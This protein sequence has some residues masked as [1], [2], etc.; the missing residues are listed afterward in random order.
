MSRTDAEVALD[1][2]RAGAAVVAARYG[3]PLD[4]HGKGGL[5]F[6]TD[7]DLEA[8][9][10]AAILAVLRTERQEDAIVGEESGA[11]GAP[12]DRTWLVDPLC[13]T[14]NFAAATPLVA[15]NVALRSG[16]DVVAAAVVDPIAGEEWWT[17]RP[18]TPSA[19]SRLVDV[20][21][22]GIRPEVFDPAA[23]IAGEACRARFGSRVLSTTLALAWGATGRRGGRRRRGGSPSAR[24]S[25]SGTTRPTSWPTRVTG[26]PMAGSAAC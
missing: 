19:S 17:G 14:L 21:L 15:V 25:S 10:E 12:G 24:A 23:L 11:T 5:D 1:A 7:A 13:G 2:A 6:A 3:R 20:N 8:E 9:A 22:D 16:S 18:P 4:R 26:P